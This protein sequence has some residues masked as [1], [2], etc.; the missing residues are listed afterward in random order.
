[1]LMPFTE[2]PRPA[3]IPRFDT[4]PG[5]TPAL[6]RP[7]SFDWRQKGAVLGIKDQGK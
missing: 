2:P 6:G 1:M 3:N 7:E 4:S 5:W